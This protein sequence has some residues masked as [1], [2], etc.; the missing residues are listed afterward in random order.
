V[1]RVAA[2]HQ[3]RQA[4]TFARI[5]RQVTNRQV[6]DQLQ[7]VL[8]GAEETVAARQRPRFFAIEDPASAQGG[9]RPQRARLPQRGI[10]GAEEQLEQL[11][12]ELNVADCSAPFLHVQRPQPGQ[13]G[14]LLHEQPDVPHVLGQRQVEPPA[15]SSRL[16]QRHE[17]A[18]Q[19]RVTRH[20]ARLD[21][22]LPFPGFHPPVVV[23]PVAGQAADQL[24][25][26]ALGA[27]PHVDA[28]E[29]SVAGLA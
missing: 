20:G 12:R 6:L 14:A 18:P 16:R 4:V 28:I 8:H 24:A 13:G 17:P 19:F 26:A 11:D 15:I 29:A 25:V 7:A 3:P 27:K 9:E 23:L 21:Q 2:A 1:R 22:R 10:L 5:S